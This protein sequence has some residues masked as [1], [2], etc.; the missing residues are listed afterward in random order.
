MMKLVL[1]LVAGLML[2]AGVG[3]WGYSGA[4]TPPM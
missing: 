2:R 3:L 4:G 1:I